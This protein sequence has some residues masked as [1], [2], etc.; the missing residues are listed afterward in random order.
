MGEQNYSHVETWD[1]CVGDEVKITQHGA[2]LF[3]KA[4]LSNVFK[5]ELAVLNVIAQLHKR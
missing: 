3:S 4:V 1:S 2:F 5:S